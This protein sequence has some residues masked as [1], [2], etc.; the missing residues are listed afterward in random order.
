MFYRAVS[1]LLVAVLVHGSITAQDQPQSPQQTVA[2][3]Q[4]VLHKTQEKGKAVKVTLNRKIDNRNKLTGKVSEISDTG[5]VLTD[6]KTGSTRK[7]AYADVREV[8]Q[9]GMSKGWTIAL[10]VIAGVIVA[11]LVASRPWQSE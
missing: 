5:F 1:V 7:L 3:M 11:A 2:K 9:K 8:H 10:V 6:Q 4:Q